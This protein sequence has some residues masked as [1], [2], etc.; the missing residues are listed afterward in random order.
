[1]IQ[2]ELDSKKS[3]KQSM[4]GGFGM[5][6]FDEEDDY[7]E[8]G[9]D[10]DQY[11]RELVDEEEEENEPEPTILKKTSIK[12]EEKP[13]TGHDGQGPL[14]GFVFG[15]QAPVQKIWYPPPKVPKDWIPKPVTAVSRKTHH[16]RGPLNPDERRDLLGEEALKAPSRS[17]F[18]FLSMK[19]QERL[20]TMT[21][22]VHVEAPE[23]TKEQALAALKGFMPFG[24]DAAK[25]TRYR[26]FLEYKA[27][28]LA[29]LPEPPPV[30]IE[31]L[32]IST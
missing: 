16:Q 25:Q 14:F 31:L 20:N 3:Q 19:D 18:S 28:M 11:D 15:D 7:E 13:T 4:R 23:V 29:S 1:L 30:S 12:K 10:T 27:G 8:F 24:N 21:E 32:N 6:I 2:L 17:V 5:G 22:Q 26:Q 9:M